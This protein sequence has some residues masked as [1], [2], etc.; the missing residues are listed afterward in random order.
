MVKDLSS[1]P[2][3]ELDKF[4]N[5]HL[6]PD[7]SFHDEVREDIEVI[8][9]FLKERC[10][11]GA[12]H[13]VRVSRVVLGGSYDEHTA[14]KGRSEANLVV[15][16]SNLTSF[17]DQL[18]LQRDFLEEIQKHLCQLEQEKQFKMKFEVQRSEQPNSRS[19]S[20]KLS[21]PQFQQ[22]VEF[23]VQPTYDALYKQRNNHKPDTQIYSE[24]YAR[25]I[26]VCTTLKKEG[27][28]S[29]CFIELQQN[30]LKHRKPKLKRLILLVK[31]WYQLCKEKLRDP[32]PPQYALE[33][34]TVYAWEC[35]SR[36]CDFNTAQ[37]FRT[38]LELVTKYKLLQIYWTVY[39]DFRH[40]EVS[41]YLHGQL[42]K[43]RPVI[44]DP[45]DPTR[46]VA[47]KNLLGWWSLAK[48]AS[49]WLQCSCFRNCDMSLVGSWDVPMS[50]K[51]PQDCVLL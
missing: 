34:L 42:K 51:F 18:N 41:N 47:A 23:D 9:A 29:N 27:E 12:A 44:L 10:F 38:V 45:A 21:Y 5:D 3:C 19:L 49:S 50:V 14:L 13:P 39:Y 31:H 17:E 28:F 35:G 16:F 25:L 2:A 7:T 40:Q 33:L 37:G 4:I 8:S 36:D 30:F 1:T 26:S 48:E 15:F 24:T 22:E 11:Q 43:A 20:F 6:L 32:L 46:N